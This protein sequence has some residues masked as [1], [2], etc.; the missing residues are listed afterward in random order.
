MVEALR[1]QGADDWLYEMAWV[2][3]P[4]GLAAGLAAPG[5]ASPPRIAARGQASFEDA[6]SPH[7]LARYE[8]LLPGL[9]SP[10]A[11]Y[12]ARALE[13]LGFAFDPGRTT[14]AEA[15]ATELGVVE[16]HRRLLGR[17]LEILAE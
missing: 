13:R 16:A 17:L 2:P 1:P 14:S 12:A 4:R 7:G 5:L 6:G 15:L 3:R 9:E 10:R 8:A 11:R